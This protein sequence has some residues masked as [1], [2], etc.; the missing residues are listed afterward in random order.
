MEYLSLEG[1][2]SPAVKGELPDII[3]RCNWTWFLTSSN[4]GQQDEE[5]IK[6]LFFVLRLLHFPGIYPKPEPLDR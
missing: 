2:L 6:T 3:L 1:K 4:Q 5:T